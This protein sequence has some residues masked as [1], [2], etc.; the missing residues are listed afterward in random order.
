[1]FSIIIPTFN[2][3]EY[4]KLCLKSLQ[5]N[6]KF[7][8]EIIIHVNEGSDGS[9]EYVNQNKL[10]HTHTINNVG[11]CTAVNLAAAQATTE[12]IIFSHDD[13]Y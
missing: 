1:M 10:L 3:L 6:S 13:M 12:Y 2:N 4:L 7:K 11:L 5:K 8:H 9:L